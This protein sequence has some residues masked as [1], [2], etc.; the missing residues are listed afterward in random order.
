[1]VCIYQRHRSLRRAVTPEGNTGR[2]TPDEDGGHNA[3][4]NAEHNAGH[5]AGHNGGH[6]G[7]PDYLAFRG[8]CITFA[9]NPEKS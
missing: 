7:G 4:Y 3:G 1:M 6:N 8:G 5:N 9:E 2:G